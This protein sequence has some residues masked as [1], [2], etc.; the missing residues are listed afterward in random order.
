MLASSMHRWWPNIKKP[1]VAD[2]S[3][4][5]L[6]ESS[7]NLPSIVDE[8]GIVIVQDIFERGKVSGELFRRLKKQPGDIICAISLLKFNKEI[9]E[10]SL[11][12]IE[13]GWSF[14]K[15]DIL[16][17]LPNH[18]LIEIQSPKECSPPTETDDDYNL[19]WI[20]PRSLHPTSYKYLRREFGAGRDPFLQRRDKILPEFD[21]I[22][23]GC[24]FTAGHYVYGHRHYQVAID[25]KKLLTG[26]IGKLIAKWIADICEGNPQRKKAE[27]ERNRGFE[28]K[29]D[30]TFV[31]M[32]LHSQ[33]GYQ[34]KAGQF[35][36]SRG[37]P[38]R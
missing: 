28:L 11:T 38:H 24:L 26:Q 5:I 32:P 1:I 25:V 15:H 31:L 20:E 37:Y 9:S 30:V 16:D 27:W 33:I 18:S 2:L 3:F 35:V 4:N 13:Q 22:D 36:N 21:S 34:H 7:A 19:F 6:L 17:D 23:D 14:N 12:S 29:C 10:T 8:G